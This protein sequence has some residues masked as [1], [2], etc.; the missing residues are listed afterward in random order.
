M[1][2]VRRKEILTSYVSD[3]MARIFSFFRSG[4]GTA[5]VRGP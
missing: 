5:A 4:Q 1:L 2:P 3:G